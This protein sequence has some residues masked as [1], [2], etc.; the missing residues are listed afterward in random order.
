MY[1]LPW[2][3]SEGRRICYGGVADDNHVFIPSSGW[4][5]ML[6]SGYEFDDKDV[7]SRDKDAVYLGCL[8]HVW[9]HAI[10]DNFKKVWYL[11]DN[12]PKNKDL[13]YITVGNKPLPQYVFDLFELIGIDL[14]QAIHITQITRY[15]NVIV[16]ENSL[17]NKNEIREYNPQF[18]LTINKI[19]SRIPILKDSPSKIYLSRTRLTNNRDTG[20]SSIERIFRERG[21]LIVSPEILSVKEQLSLVR[22]CQIFASTEGSISHSSIF[23]KPGTD[24]IL[25]KKVDYVNPYTSFINDMLELKCTFIRAHNSVLTPQDRPWEGPFFL[26]RSKELMS[27]FNKCFWRPYFLY[28]SWYEYRWGLWTRIKKAYYS[29]KS[30]CRIRARI[31]Q[32]FQ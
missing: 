3:P 23:C 11:F 24:I 30:F 13:V 32:W 10:T 16:P 26:Y 8:Y 18:E 4:H 15:N 31:F 29:I 17:V 6:E 9:G 19:T 28:L 22:N 25:I 12:T 7:V 27:Y 20:E 2:I 1:V 14:K 5:E 21:F